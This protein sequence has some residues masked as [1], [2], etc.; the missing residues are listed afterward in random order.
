MT[1]KRYRVS[2]NGFRCNTQTWDNVYQMDGKADEVFISTGVK[3]ANKN[4]ELLFLGTE[5]RSPVMGDTNNQPNRI[6]AS[7]ACGEKGGIITRD[8]FPTGAPWIRIIPLSRERDYP[9]ISVWE[10]DLIQGEHT[11]HHPDN[12]GM[13]NGEGSMLEGWVKWQKETDTDFGMK[14]H[15]GG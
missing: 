2:I 12:L 3:Y 14:V 15:K 10:G 1:S 13:D 11:V 8:V 9:P 5:K 7:S 4:G 6:K